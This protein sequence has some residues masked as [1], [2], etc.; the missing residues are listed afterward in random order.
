VRRHKNWALRAAYQFMTESPL[1]LFGRGLARN[2][3]TPGNFGFDSSAKSKNN[4]SLG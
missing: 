2:S 3:T 1:T 4:T